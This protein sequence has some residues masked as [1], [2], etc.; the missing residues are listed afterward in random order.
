[1]MFSA[2]ISGSHHRKSPSLYE[3]KKL[4]GAHSV[5]FNTPVQKADLGITM[6]FNGWGEIITAWPKACCRGSTCSFFS[7]LSSHS[8]CC[9]QNQHSSSIAQ[10]KHSPF[11]VGGVQGS[12]LQLGVSHTA[13][14]SWMDTW[15]FPIFLCLP[16]KNEAS[17]TWITDLVM[18]STPFITSNTQ[19]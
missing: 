9:M 19:C 5:C 1:M 8:A 6:T 4:H 14:E 16:L 15:L 10:E 3:E 11:G 7:P 18:L 17:K 12:R 2:K 13:L